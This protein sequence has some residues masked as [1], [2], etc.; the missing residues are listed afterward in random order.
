M[1]A[2]RRSLDLRLRELGVEVR[3]F[4]GR[5]DGFAGLLFQGK[6]FGHFHS[7]C[8]IDIRLGK[9][10]IKREGLVHPVDSTVHPDRA[11]GSPWYEMKLTRTTDVDEA[12]RLVKLAIEALQSRK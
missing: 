7:P 2:I 10:I 11:K 6:D 9:D 8:E 4:P 5:D 3:A 1:N 12:I